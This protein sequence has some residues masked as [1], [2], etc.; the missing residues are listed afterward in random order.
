MSA[1]REVANA[2]GAVLPVRVARR[3][4]VLAAAMAGVLL[5]AGPAAAHAT[6]LTT[7]PAAGY[8]GAGPVRQVV[9][10]F[11]EPVTVTADSVRVT[12]AAGRRVPGATLRTAADGRQLTLPLVRQRR[13]AN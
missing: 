5:P 6:L 4:L 7:V 10:V 8:A 1:G 3:L 12:D 2:P 13:S 9:L 11:D